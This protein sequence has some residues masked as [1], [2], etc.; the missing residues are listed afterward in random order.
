VHKTI[1]QFFHSHPELLFLALAVVS[2]TLALRQSRR[3][4]LLATLNI[5]IGV[6]AVLFL[7]LQL[8]L[9]LISALK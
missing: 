4:S 8:L 9:D 5:I 7:L 6:I 3:G 2:F 1:S